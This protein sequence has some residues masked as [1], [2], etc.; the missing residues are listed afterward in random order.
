MTDNNAA[1]ALRQR[2]G[3]SVELSD[4]NGTTA[5][6]RIAAEITLGANRYAILQTSQMQREDEIEVF[7]ILEGAGGEFELESVAD[8]EEWELVEEAFDDLQFGDEE[9]P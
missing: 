5:T 3:D 4:E 2:Y 1:S 6:Y 7:R 9:Q 8:E